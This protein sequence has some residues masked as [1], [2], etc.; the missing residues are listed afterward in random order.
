MKN[1]L[2]NI[3]KFGVRSLTALLFVTAGASINAYA[4][5]DQQNGVI[6]FSGAVVFPPC[7]NDITDKHVTLN[8]LNN[9]SDMVANKMN[10]NDVKNT[11]GWKVIN[12]GR[13]EYSYNWVNEEKQLGMLTIKY[14]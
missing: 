2:S 9:Q 11:Q 4:N 6:N 5:N 1:S 7:F 13:G 10:L 8:C 14:I 3:Q 12:D